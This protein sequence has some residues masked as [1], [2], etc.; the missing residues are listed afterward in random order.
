MEVMECNRCGKR[1]TYSKKK[2]K[3]ET[4]KHCN[5]C[6]TMLRHDRLKAEFV[7]MLGG[8]CCRCGYRKCISALCFHHRSSETK[9]FNVGNNLNRS[10]YSL[11]EEVKKCDLLC[12]N[13]HTEK[14]S[15]K[16]G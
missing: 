10:K 4:R 13:C 2:R 6:V 8:K 1:Y 5:S 12:L 16:G 3:G 15:N 9:L 7:E 11:L 14:H